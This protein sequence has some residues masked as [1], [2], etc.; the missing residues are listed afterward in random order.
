MKVKIL[1]TIMLTPLL[2]SCLST[3]KAEVAEIKDI[4]PSDL[5][6]LSE[7][8]ITVINASPSGKL[9]A[10][11][12]EAGLTVSGNTAFGSLVQLDRI[13]P[14]EE[15]E[16]VL[17][18]DKLND[19]NQVDNWAAIGL[20]ARQGF[21]TGDETDETAGGIGVLLRLGVEEGVENIGF[22]VMDNPGLAEIG[23]ITLPF[24]SEGVYILNLKRGESEWIFTINDQT[25]PISYDFLPEDNYRNGK[26]FFFAAI[27]TNGT[28]AL[29]FKVRRINNYA[30]A[31]Y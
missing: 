23:T 4:P 29:S 2:F 28:E 12:S 5:E 10:Q 7:E 27:H 24:T 16:I 1:I 15:A 8:D 20:T 14:A 9:K 13:I 19:N 11:Q 6:Y 26:G 22:Q 30:F 21:L 31:E 17:S 25:L 18:V 3:P